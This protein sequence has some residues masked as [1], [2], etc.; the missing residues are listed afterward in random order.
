MVRYGIWSGGEKIGKINNYLSALK[1]IP[2][3]STNF[4]VENFFPKDL[5]KAKEI[6]KSMR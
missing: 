2:I 4:R 3:H 5:Q 6:L 1:R